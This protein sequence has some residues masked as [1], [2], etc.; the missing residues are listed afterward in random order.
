MEHSLYQLFGSISIEY[1]DIRKEQHLRYKMIVE[2]ST[3]L[4]M[5]EKSNWILLG[6]ILSNKDLKRAE[7]L[8]ISEELKRLRTGKLLELLNKTLKNIS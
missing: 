2:N 5:E 7:L 4:T 3:I 8:L 6:Y 1:D